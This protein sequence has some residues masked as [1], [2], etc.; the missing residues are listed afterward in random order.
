MTTVSFYPGC[1]LEATARDYRESLEAAADLLDLKLVELPGWSCCGAS[2]AHALDQDL[3]LNL[4]ARNLALAARAPAPLVVPCALCFHRLKAAQATLAREPERLA[5]AIRALGGDLL[6]VEVVEAN[7]FFTSPE[8]VARAAAALGQPLQGLA[9]AVYY[10]CQGQRPPQVTQ[11]KVWEHPAHLDGL[12]TA[13]G[14]APADWD[15]QTDC[16][17]ASLAV[18][19]PTI[20][21]ELTGRLFT[22]ALEAGANC[23]VTG[24]QMCQANL[25]MYQPGVS[26][27]LGR[28]LD[29]PVFYFTELLGL[30]L[31]HAQAPRWLAR[32]L[33]NPSLLLAH[34]GLLPAARRQS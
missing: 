7:H 15:R 26:R 24:C 28:E 22:A 16:C 17:G 5:P 8:L 4:A 3:A 1:S 10:G 6:A 31:G 9:P 14:A 2:A 23:L 20:V 11:S 29:L 27:D 18:A 34:L 32:H 33:V 30:A 19:E 12:L 13:L 21:R 25:D